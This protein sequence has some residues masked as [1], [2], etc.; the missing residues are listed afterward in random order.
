MK[1]I[2]S[3]RGKLKLVTGLEWNEIPKYGEIIFLKLAEKGIKIKPD[4]TGGVDVID[5]DDQLDKKLKQLEE[6]NN[7]EKNYN[8]EKKYNGEKNYK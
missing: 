6:K 7:G 1:R 4:V 5:L 3:V 8:G 2:L